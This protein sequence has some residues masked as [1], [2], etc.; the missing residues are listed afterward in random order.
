QIEILGDEDASFSN[1]TYIGKRY[2]DLTLDEISFFQYK[3]QD[4]C[5]MLKSLLLEA[6]N[7]RRIEEG[8][9][10]IPL[11]TFYK[12]LGN[13]MNSM[14]IDEND[15]YRWLKTKGINVTEKY[16]IENARASIQTPFSFRD[17]K[18]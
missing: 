7:K 18:N 16:F 4:N 1:F 5:L 2:T 12:F 8:K 15:H 14:G 17:L 11:S 9:S 13:L 10:Q 6:L 3:L